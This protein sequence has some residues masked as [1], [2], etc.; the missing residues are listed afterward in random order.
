MEAIGFGRMDGE[1]MATINGGK[2]SLNGRSN[3]ALNLA[4][5]H[6]ANLQLFAC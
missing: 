1:T 4:G 3:R 6:T 5:N 2:P